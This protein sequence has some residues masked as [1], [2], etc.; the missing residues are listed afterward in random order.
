M[1]NLLAAT[2]AASARVLIGPTADYAG[3]HALAESV[4][5][6]CVLGRC[7]NLCFNCSATSPFFLSYFFLKFDMGKFNLQSLGKEGGDCYTV[8]A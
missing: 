3:V 2:S 4:C 5:Q 7:A 6:N 8:L 1:Q